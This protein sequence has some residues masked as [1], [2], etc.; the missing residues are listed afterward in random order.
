MGASGNGTGTNQ[1]YRSIHIL[2]P[3]TSCDL[4]VPYR[5]RLASER[6]ELG[7]EV[8]AP[9]RDRSIALGGHVPAA[10]LICI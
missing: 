1:G 5:N 10:K 7:A 3:T 2:F 4:S 8:N 6:L 9:Y